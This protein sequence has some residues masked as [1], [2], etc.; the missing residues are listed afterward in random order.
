MIYSVNA[1]L[2]TSQ[3]TIT[4]TSLIPKSKIKTDQTL[5]SPSNTLSL[6]VS[7]LLTHWGCYPPEFLD[8]FMLGILWVISSKETVEL[9]NYWFRVLIVT[10]PWF[11][12]NK[13]DLHLF[14][15]LSIGWVPDFLS[16]KFFLSF[17]FICSFPLIL[18]RFNFLQ[19]GVLF[20]VLWIWYI[21]MKLYCYLYRFSI[22]NIKLE[23]DGWRIKW[24]L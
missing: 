21:Y 13:L 3:S 22:K 16:L 4:L 5:L 14:V 19:S 15:F 12:V 1:P 8:P 10:N 7:R 20:E 6:S 24:L 23:S 18:G 11:F 9:L 2:P 17:T